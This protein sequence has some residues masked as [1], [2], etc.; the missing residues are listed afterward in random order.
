MFKETI[1]S[2]MAQ[3]VG[4]VFYFAL[5]IL[6]ARRLGVK[7]F[8]TWSYFYSII[9]IL[10][11]FSY[12]GINPSIRVFLARFNKTDLLGNVLKA[13]LKLRFLFSIIIAVSFFI[14]HKQIAVFLNRPDLK[15]LFLLASPLFILKGLTEYLKSVFQG[16]HRLKYHF[17]INFLE[18][19]L[20]L[21]FVF[22][23]FIYSANVL[24]VIYSF[25]LAFLLTSVIGLVLLF[26]KFYKRRQPSKKKFEKKIL[27]YSFPLFLINLGFIVMTELDTTMLG[28]LSTDTEVGVFSVAKQVVTNLPHIS[29]A[30]ATGTMPIFAK[31]NNSNR[32]KLRKTFY[33]L[34]KYNTA[35]FGVITLGILTLGWYFI[36]LIFGADYSKSTTILILL[37]PYMLLS[38]YSV[39][40]SSLLDYQGLANKRAANLSIAAVLNLA[41]NLLLIPSYGAGGAAVATSASYIPYVFLNWREV[42]K[43]L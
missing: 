4:F 32:R 35:I 42:K 8:G 34:L 11:V 1:W 29:L 25:N 38:S 13:S 7:A 16:L 36:P 24:N 12:L 22:L 17:M 43:L 26:L 27:K 5:N 20:K 9:S 33:K 15:T 28:F 37:T 18:Y 6:L 3:G 41:L 23:L 39:F 10:L 2:F 19:G 40:L 31:L 30:I 14:A 21:L